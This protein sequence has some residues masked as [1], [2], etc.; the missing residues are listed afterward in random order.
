MLPPFQ[1]TDVEF[2]YNVASLSDDCDVEFSYNVAS[3]P[4]D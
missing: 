1:M 2:S 3:L 4:D